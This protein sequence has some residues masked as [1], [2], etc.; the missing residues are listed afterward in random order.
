LTAAEVIELADAEARTQGYDLGKYQRPQA[1]YAATENI[2]SV[3]YDQKNDAGEAGKP[4]SVK[5]EDK[6]KKTSIVAGK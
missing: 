4:F 1:Q 3:S 2:W 6:T 5:V